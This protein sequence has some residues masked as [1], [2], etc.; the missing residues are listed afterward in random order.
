MPSFAE[1]YPVWERLNSWVIQA[2]SLGTF[3]AT[4]QLIALSQVDTS[5]FLFFFIFL[6]IYYFYR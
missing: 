4:Q 3:V 6:S 1:T 5:D 2:E